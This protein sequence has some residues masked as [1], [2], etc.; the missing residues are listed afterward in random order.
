LGVSD[1]A[2]AERIREDGVDILVDLTQHMAGNRLQTF[3]R[4]PAPIQVSFAGY[5]ASTGLDAIPYR[6]SD[7]F[8]ERGGFQPGNTARREYVFLLDSFWCYDPCGVNVAVNQL[9]AW[10]SGRLTFGSLNNFCKVNE[11]ALKLWGRVLENVAES[12]LI[13]LSPKGSHRDWALETLARAGIE[14]RRVEF[15]EVCPRQTY[16]EM[17]HLLDIVLDPYPYC[18]HTTSLDALWMGVPVVT[19][20]GERAVCRASLSQLSNLG[21]PDLVAFSEDEYVSIAVQLAGELPRLAEL[22]ATLRT[23]MEASPLMDAP[24]FARQVHVAYRTMWR[25]WCAEK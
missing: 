13:L 16:L 17:H 8:L 11:S 6:I 18:G 1:E 14:A 5:P 25:R 2:L 22:R 10:E 9:P 19:L 7:R 3:A 23:H 20:A 24:R 15:V 21:L 4:Q 12:R